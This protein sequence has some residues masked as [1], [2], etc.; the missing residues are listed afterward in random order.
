MDEH[1]YTE[2]PHSPIEEKQFTYTIKGITLTFVSV[3][4]VFAFSQKVD[5]ASELLIENFSPSGSSILDIG[6]GYGAIGLFMKKL[7]NG[8]DVCM[9]DINGRA[10]NYAVKNAKANELDVY[11]LKSDLF[12]SLEGRKFDDIVSNPPFAAGKKLNMEL[13]NQS[14]EHLNPRGALWLVAFHNKGGETLKKAMKERFGNAED[15]EKSGG[16]RVYKSVKT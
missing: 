1:Y 12:G 5:R 9:A 14:F 2:D 10:V 3:S 8:Q 13:I 16:I 7:Y 6:C 11:T 4:G 15:V